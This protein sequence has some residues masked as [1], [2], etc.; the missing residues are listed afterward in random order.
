MRSRGYTLLEL[1][2]TLTLAV[3]LLAL[4]VP[5]LRELAL[6]ARRTADVNALVSA[7]HLARACHRNSSIFQT[8][9]SRTNSRVPPAP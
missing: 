1:L 3:V 2:V 5:G 8:A 6:D 4:G 7:I 9:C